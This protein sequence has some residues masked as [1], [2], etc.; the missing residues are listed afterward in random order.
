MKPVHWHSTKL[1]L[2]GLAQAIILAF[3]WGFLGAVLL[4]EPLTLSDS[5]S[6]FMHLEP[7][8]ST[9]VVTLIST[10]LALATGACFSTAVKEA[11]SHRMYKP[12]SLIKLSGGIALARGSFLTS[13]GHLGLTIGTLVI[14]GVTRLMVSS[15]ATLLTPTLVAWEVPATGWELDITTSGFDTLLQQELISSGAAEIRGNS[16]EIIDVGGVLSGISAAGYSFGLPGI[17]NFNGV[18]YNV[19]TGGIL[20]VAPSYTGTTQPAQGNN[21]GL[22]FAGGLVPAN[23]TTHF[24]PQREIKGISSNYTVQ[25][26]G[27]TANVTC[28]LYPAQG[29]LSLSSTYTPV[30]IPL[31]NGQTDYWLWAWNI[32]A[33]CEEGGTTY[34]QYVT[35]SNSSTTPQTESS[36]FVTSVVCPYPL[37]QTNFTWDRFV[38][39]SNGSWKYN[40]LPLTVCEVVPSFTTSIVNYASKSVNAT[41]TNTT[42]LG[43]DHPSLLKFLAAVIDYQ[44]RNTQGLTSN[45]IGDSLYSIYTSTATS[46][47]TD[48]TEQ[49]LDE[50]AQYWRGVIEFSGTFLRS[51]F[52]AYPRTIPSDALAGVTGKHTIMTMGWS[53]R[54]PAYLYTVLPLT[55]VALLTF[56]AIAYSLVHMWTE[57]RNQTSFNTFDPSNPVHLMMVSSAEAPAEGSPPVQMP[58]LEKRLKGFDDEGIKANE[59][60]RV[61]LG[62]LPDDRKGFAVMQRIGAAG[63]SL[64]L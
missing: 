29:N 51:G 26:Q 45:S 17:F 60:V 11:L 39:T 12:I 50:L 35:R 52:S 3:A 15:W 61:H 14:Y 7:T 37:Q 21:T 40:F 64:V 58:D 33:A 32:T 49:L 8:E 27:L 4:R 38:V 63:P 18:L 13:F 1:L 62:D 56:S 25:Q 53:K 20:P 23:L 30:P 19:S 57:H 31:A 16:F 46:N 41:V 44:A 55:F 22:A 43:T 10:V 6:R 2:A 42:T 47:S 28:S 54:S 9:L 34:Q 59:L 5:V 48:S 24:P 36:G